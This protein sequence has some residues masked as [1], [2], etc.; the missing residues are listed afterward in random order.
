MRQYDI[1]TVGHGAIGAYAHNV[2]SSGMT[3]TE[4]L[5]CCA[6][7]VDL[8]TIPWND[9]TEF[10][11]CG[12]MLNVD[13]P[14]GGLQKFGSPT[15]PFDPTPRE[16][17]DPRLGQAASLDYAAIDVYLRIAR[18]FGATLIKGSWPEETSAA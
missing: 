7:V 9:L 16:G 3:R 17:R 2:H 14:A 13:V 12:P 8:T 4:A 15:L 5:K 6:I 10:S 1:A 11:I 18:S